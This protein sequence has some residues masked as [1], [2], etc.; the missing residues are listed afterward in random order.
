MDCYLALCPCPDLTAFVIGDADSSRTSRSR[1]TVA[2]L[3]ACPG[4]RLGKPFSVGSSPTSEAAR[5]RTGP[6]ARF[7]AAVPTPIGQDGGVTKTY[8]LGAARR[9]CLFRQGTTQG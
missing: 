6:T 5:T 7:D 9:G 4:V 1:P 8:K 3:P 2:A